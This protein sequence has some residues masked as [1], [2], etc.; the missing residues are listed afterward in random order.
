MVLK[1]GLF[2][3]KPPPKGWLD[4]DQRYVKIEVRRH[5]FLRVMVNWD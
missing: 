1:V 2:N 5:G 3:Q 4:F